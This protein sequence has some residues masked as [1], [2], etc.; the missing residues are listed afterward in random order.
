MKTT[1]RD[2][3]LAVF[4]YL[5]RAAQENHLPAFRRCMSRGPG[6]GPRAR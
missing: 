5:Q 1:R 3:L 2:D 6:A 4:A